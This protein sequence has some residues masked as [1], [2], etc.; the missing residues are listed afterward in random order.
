[1]AG[2][3]ARGAQV[4]E[5]ENARSRAR[6]EDLCR[7]SGLDPSSA[8]AALLQPPEVTLSSCRIE[9][10]LHLVHRETRQADAGV[11]LGGRLKHS[12]YQARFGSAS[13]RE[14]RIA[15]EIEAAPERP[16]RALLKI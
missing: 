6:F 1:M 3:A 7:Q 10:S 11:V 5:E 15:L 12:F 4:L 2:D 16:A 8:A 9:A 13:E 14:N